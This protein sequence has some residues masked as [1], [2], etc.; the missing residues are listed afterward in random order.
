MINWTSLFPSNSN[1]P[2]TRSWFTTHLFSFLLKILLCILTIPVP[3]NPPK[4]GFRCL[5]ETCKM[6]FHIYVWSSL[7]EIWKRG[8]GVDF[9]KRGVVERISAR[10][11]VF[12]YLSRGRKLSIRKKEC[13]K[14]AVLHT[15]GLIF[16]D[17]FLEKTHWWKCCSRPNCKK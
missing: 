1:Q 4:F 8:F 10:L 12:F 6:E 11:R 5:H 16:N 17:E 2:Y 15:S 9:C 3:C 7:V 14:R 13:W